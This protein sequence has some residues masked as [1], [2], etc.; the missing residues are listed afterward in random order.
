MKK[1]L[2]FFGLI[3][4]LIVSF[5]YNEKVENVIKMNDD[6]LSEIKEKSLFYK[7]EKIEAY[8]NNNTIIPGING[9]D[10]DVNKSYEK[11]KKEG[12]FDEKK[13]V[14]KKNIVKNKLSDNKDK[15]IISGNNSLKKVS[16]FLKID[17]ND[18]ISK[19]KNKNVTFVV[20]NNIN[21]LNSVAYFCENEDCIYLKNYLNRFYKN[22]F[23]VNSP[24]CLKM[25]EYTLKIT[26]V[27]ESPFLFVK[28]NLKSGFIFYF[29]VNEKLIYE[30]DLITDYIE[31]KGFEIVMIYD[32]LKE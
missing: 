25:N 9:M 29:D 16:I 26:E 1:I 18:D 23:C 21:N 7:K 12:F 8:I 24:F 30:F 5:S 3:T 11:M 6:L 28:E 32:L 10:V 15:Y 19:F 14:Y 4:L 13:L 2:R 20:N 22:V 27:N 17:F 31:S